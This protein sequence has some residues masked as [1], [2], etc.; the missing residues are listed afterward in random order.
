M[1]NLQVGVSY[2]DHCPNSGQSCLSLLLPRVPLTSEK[3]ALKVIQIAKQ[4]D[5]RHIGKCLW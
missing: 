4:R 2:L 5:L 3:R 1:F